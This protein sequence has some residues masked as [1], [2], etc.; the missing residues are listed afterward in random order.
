[1]KYL[2]NLP[3]GQTVTFLFATNDGNGAAVAPT[4]V[5]TISVYKDNGISETAAG[6][7]YTPSFDGL[8]GVNAVTITTTDAFYAAGH[9]FAVVLSGA[10]IDGE[11]VNA[12]LAQFSIANRRAA[13][14]F[15]WAADVSNPP[16]IPTKEQ[17]ATQVETQIISETD[18]NLV[19]KAITDKIAA[20]NPSLSGL[21]L[22]AIASQVRTELSTE[23][24]RI[25]AAIS[26]R[27]AAAGYTAPP[28][29]AQNAAA[30]AAALLLTPANKLASDSLGQVTASNPGGLTS[31]QSALLSSVAS[32]A[33]T[34][35]A[36]ERNAVADALL[37]RANA[38]DGKTLQEALRIMAAV[39]AGRVTGAGTGT[40]TFK[41]L[42]GA[43]VRA[44]VSTD[45]D[46]NRT[47]V[48]Y[49]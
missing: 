20:V 42:D 6:V 2:G 37:T 38:V 1:M 16:T 12:V 35:T 48:A 45:A 32:A 3:A 29:A 7:T 46:A 10:V 44:I 11:T 18:G 30:S 9:D 17:I 14:T 43:T 49:S 40:E 28:T 31:E 4:T 34:L 41:G 25:D 15:D 33:G 36:A 21:T 27:L 19:L 13:A 23:L 5:G 47:N 8:T 24:A 39:L 26:S 22:A